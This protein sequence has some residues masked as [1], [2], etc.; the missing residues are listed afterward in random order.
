[1]LCSA[2]L[3]SALLCCC[4]VLHPL[5]SHHSQLGS[6]FSELHG[7][8]WKATFRAAY[9]SLPEFL[10]SQHN[11]FWTDPELT[12]VLL[13]AGEQ[14]PT[15]PPPSKAAAATATATTTKTEME[16][17]AK[18]KEK[19]LE[20]EKEKETEREKEVEQWKWFDFNDGM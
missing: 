17:E 18:Q 13:L 8:P 4:S 5:P 6:A 16:N 19:E 12:Q 2:A 1:M 14:P 7:R 10:K 3:C 9:G 15:P 11:V 20:K